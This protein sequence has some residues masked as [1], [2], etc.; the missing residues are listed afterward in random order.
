[1]AIVSESLWQ[2]ER[3]EEV[4]NGLNRLT[5]EL[6]CWRTAY[7][8]TTFVIGLQCQKWQSGSLLDGRIEAVGGL[9]DD[10]SVAFGVFQKL[11]ESASPVY[12]D[13][14]NE[15]VRDLVIGVGAVRGR[16][17]KLVAVATS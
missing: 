14:L 7:G 3:R 13:H 16:K 8:E 11:S 2:V 12:P 10:P 5:Y 6:F 4:P 15:V 17:P 9:G 1:M